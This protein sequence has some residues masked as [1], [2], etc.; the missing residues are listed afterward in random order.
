MQLTLANRLTLLRVALVPPVALLVTMDDPVARIVALLLFLVAAITDYLD[1]RIARARGEIS[2]F[3]RCLDPIADKLLVATVLIALL[4]A[5][6]A[7]W[8]PVLLIVLRELAIA[9]LREF[10][11]GRGP[12]LPVTSLAKWKTTVQLVALALLIV[13]DLVPYVRLGGDVLLWV[14]AALTVVTA[15]GYVRSALG[16]LG[17]AET[18]SVTKAAGRNAGGAKG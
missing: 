6:R 1:G 8:V 4:A 13:G 2:D 5:D 17:L 11:A 9:G 15:I 14:A 10:L 3:G 18:P 7:P 16:F 12:T